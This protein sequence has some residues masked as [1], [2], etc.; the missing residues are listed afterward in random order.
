MSSCLLLPLRLTK[1]MT[2]IMNIVFLSN[3]FNHHQKPLSDELFSLLKGNYY[4][5]ETMPIEEERVNLGWRN[6][7]KND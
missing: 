6:D 3:Y 7:K 2:I 1:G 5:I 4:F